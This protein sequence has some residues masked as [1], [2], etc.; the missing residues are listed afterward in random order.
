MKSRIVDYVVLACALVVLGARAEA[1]PP[2]TVEIGSYP[3]LSATAQPEGK[4]TFQGEL[5]D[6]LGNALQRP[7]MLSHGA[8][9]D[10]AMGSVEGTIYFESP[11]SALS[12]TRDGPTQWSQLA[13]EQVCMTH[14]APYAGE[15]VRRFAVVPRFYPSAAHALI[16]L[17]LGECK[18]VALEDRLLG[19]IAQLPE[20]VRYNRRID[21]IAGYRFAQAI[22]V[23]DQHL[24]QA[25]TEQIEEW[26]TSG[27]LDQLVQFWVDEVAFEAYVLS[28]TLD[29]H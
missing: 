6:K 19:D 17:K 16:G 18:A 5:S 2:L 21:P 9:V 8:D 25:I 7:V 23:H 28:D 1:G 14:R 20:W 15:L 3:L 22:R 13:R 11:I 4:H 26:E 29:C 27:E 24:Q 12:D 10:L